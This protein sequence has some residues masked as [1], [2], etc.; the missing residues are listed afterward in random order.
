MRVLLVEDDA[1][2]GAALSDVLRVHGMEVEHVTTARMALARLTPQTEAVVLDL[3]LPDRDGFEVCS[4]IRRTHDVPILIATARSDLTARVHGLNLGADDYLVKP[5]DVR[6]L[7]ARLHAVS[8]R[9][10]RELVGAGAG[11]AVTDA[12]EES[13]LGTSVGPD[14]DPVTEPAPLSPDEVVID[15]SSRTVVKGGRS[16]ALTRK[17]FDLLALLA[18]H[19]GVVFRREQIISE[20]WQ[21]TW[22]GCGRTLEVHV[23]AVRSKTGS[24]GLIETVRGVGYRLAIGAA[25][26]TWS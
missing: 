12:F 6:E 22:D 19:P 8:R 18:R 17:E 5:Y 7:L 15:V 10:R 13:E 11:G 14:G 16:I 21:S 1:R 9:H 23:A 20:V 4:R 3:G 2:L 26:S 25:S 24:P